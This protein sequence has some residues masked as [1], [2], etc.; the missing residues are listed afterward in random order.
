[1]N[2]PEKN[3][4]PKV[5]TFTHA[6]ALELGQALLGKP[7][8]A[9]VFINSILVFLHRYISELQKSLIIGMITYQI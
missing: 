2:T 9:P 1:M 6:E 8:S 4:R 5:M 7:S 3:E